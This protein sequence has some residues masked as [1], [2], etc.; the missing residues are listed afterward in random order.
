MKI[1]VLHTVL[2]VLTLCLLLVACGQKELDPTEYGL[3]AD[4]QVVEGVDGRPWIVKQTVEK[5]LP[6]TLPEAE[7]FA[8]ISHA[9]DCLFGV[10]KKEHEWALRQIVHARYD[11]NKYYIRFFDDEWLYA[12]DENGTYWLYEPHGDTFRKQKTSKTEEEVKAWFFTDT[13]EGSMSIAMICGVWGEPTGKQLELRRYDY[14]KGQDDYVVCDEYDFHGILQYAD[15]QTGLAIK[16]L[17]C[18]DWRDKA[19]NYA[20]SGTAAVF[21]F[22]ERFVGDN[23]WG[24][25]SVTGQMPV[26]KD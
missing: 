1:K 23:V 22:Q 5:T 25:V 11:T 12:P 6:I 13:C 8:L 4:V 16:T 15:P 19:E 17:A 10:S 14:F 2:L 26:L 21:L 20:D 24:Q 3:P 7:D 18:C 9:N